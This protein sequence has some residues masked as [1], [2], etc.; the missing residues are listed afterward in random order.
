M[1]LADTIIE[2]LLRYTT[3]DLICAT[4]SSNSGTIAWNKQ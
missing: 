4:S 2:Q 1:G 3:M